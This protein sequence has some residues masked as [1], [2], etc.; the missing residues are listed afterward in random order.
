MKIQ[1]VE[2]ELIEFG[3]ADTI[4]T[5]NTFSPVGIPAFWITSTGLF[6]FDSWARTNMPEDWNYD[7]NQE[8]VIK[9]TSR[10]K[11]LLIGKNTE[12]SWKEATINIASGTDI[13]PAEGYMDPK[14]DAGYQ[15][16]LNW[17]LG[18]EQN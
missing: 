16:V 3:C 12:T 2:L 9:Y 7:T 5:S 15:Q 10:Y 6:A 13:S 4:L 17:L 18:I 1:K 8:T 14:N 11:F